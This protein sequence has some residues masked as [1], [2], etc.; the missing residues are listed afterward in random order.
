MPERELDALDALFGD[1]LAP[2]RMDDLRAGALIGA[3]V[4]DERAGVPGAVAS[5]LQWLADPERFSP[6]WVAA[7]EQTLSRARDR[8]A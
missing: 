3:A 8:G 1:R 5:L 7:V 6:A 4:A 2:A